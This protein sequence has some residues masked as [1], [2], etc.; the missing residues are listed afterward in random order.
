MKSRLLKN[1]VM[2]IF[3][4]YFIWSVFSVITLHLEVVKKLENINNITEIELNENN[5]VELEKAKLD[6]NKKEMK[7]KES[8]IVFSIIFG[9]IVGIGVYVI[10]ENTKKEKSKRKIIWGAVV[11][12][13]LAF[14]SGVAIILA[15][16]LDKGLGITTEYIIN[17]IMFVI[18][19]TIVIAI[20]IV[21]CIIYINEGKKDKLNEQLKKINNK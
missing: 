8:D 21:I 20:I 2:S 17:A 15:T 9:S 1:I 19:I 18:I 7:S 16:L 11:G 10:D 14:V 6:D 13:V 5:N 12:Y 3:I 4:T